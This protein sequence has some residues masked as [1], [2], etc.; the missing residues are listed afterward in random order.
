MTESTLRPDGNVVAGSD[1]WVPPP[2]VT[3]QLL[4]EAMGAL[5]SPEERVAEELF[6]YWDEAH[7]CGY[8]SVVHLLHNEAV[9]AHATALYLEDQ[10]L[11][12][13][14]GRDEAWREAARN[15]GVALAHMGF[16]H[17]VRRRAGDAVVDLNALR[18]AL[19]RALLQPQAVLAAQRD[20]AHVGLR[21]CRGGLN[22]RQ[23]QHS[24][25]QSR[26]GPVSHRRLPAAR[27]HVQFTGD[28]RWPPPWCAA[29]AKRSTVR[30]LW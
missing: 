28:A 9:R 24:C 11:L 16:W 23:C 15:W 19:P 1:L 12:R 10:W 4:D 13:G 20:G 5:T 3:R 22:H 21:R 30:P 14:E 2:R 6:W 17:H 26:C 7:G 29:A 27:G 18:A 25:D 8:P